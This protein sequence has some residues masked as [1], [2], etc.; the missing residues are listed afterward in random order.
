MA[1]SS[2]L[3]PVASKVGST[4]DSARQTARSARETVEEGRRALPKLKGDA[5]KAFDDGVDQL[6]HQA[7]DAADQ[8]GDQFDT[9]KLYM[10][11]RVQ[12]RPM[13]ATLAALGAGFVLGLLFAGGRR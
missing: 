11:E 7:R 4:L 10:V 12:E 2:T 6:R 3:D 1:A 8:A 5:R 13:T 9:A